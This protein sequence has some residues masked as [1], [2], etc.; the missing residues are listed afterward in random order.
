MQPFFSCHNSLMVTDKKETDSIL[1]I[2][3]RFYVLSAVPDDY[4]VS[5][6]FT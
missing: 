5:L 4:F 6:T 1:R 3:V 2:G